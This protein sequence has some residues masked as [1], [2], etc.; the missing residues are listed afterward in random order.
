MKNTRISRYSTVTSKKSAEIFLFDWLESTIDPPKELKKRVKQYRK[1]GDKRLKEQLPCVTI[2]AVFNKIRNLESI[3]HKNNLLV[4]DIDRG[5]N[6]CIDMIGVRDF[7]AKHPSCLFTGLSCGG[8]GVYA[9]IVLA[10]SKKLGKYFE[11][12]KEKLQKVGVN[13][14]ASCKDYTRLRFYSYDKDA[15]FN[16]K[17]IPYNLPK[18]IKR[19]AP[20]VGAGSKSSTEKIERL[21]AEIR[22]TATDI[23]SN[24]EDWIRIGAAI[25]NEFG[26]SGNYYFH[27]ISR[28]H[29]DY[30]QGKT[31]RKYISCLKMTR[32]SFGSLFHIAGQYGIRY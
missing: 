30:N 13:I 25:A 28:L 8:D 22:S 21:I 23:T 9:I 3:S 19:K 14:D 16:K 31:D 12:F 17:A 29:P 4:I 24:Y 7:L 26:D 20:K 11:H 27:E 2:S 32:V 10:K 5:D 15:H 1:T 18:K 6:L